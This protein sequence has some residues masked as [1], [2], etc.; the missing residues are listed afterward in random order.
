[1]SER[2]GPLLSDGSPEEAPH[3]VR[4]DVAAFTGA[5]PDGDCALL[6]VEFTPRAVR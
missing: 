3:R 1:M 4:A 2:A 6:L 5:P